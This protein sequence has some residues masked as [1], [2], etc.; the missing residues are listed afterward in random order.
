MKSASKANGQRQAR[1]LSAA[2]RRQQRLNLQK[3]KQPFIPTCVL[4]ALSELHLP[5]NKRI[6]TA[7][8]RELLGA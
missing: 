5:R 7:K 8:L 3:T 4:K 6:Y 1:R 2:G